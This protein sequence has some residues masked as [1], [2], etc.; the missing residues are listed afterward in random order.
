[1]AVSNIG[2]TCTGIT[3]WRA[4]SDGWFITRS[5]PSSRGSDP[6]GDFSQSSSTPCLRARMRVRH[7]SPPDSSA[8]SSS[9]AWIA[10]AVEL[11]NVC[12]LLPPMVV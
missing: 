9:P 1:M 10:R 12:G 6:S 8:T 11:T 2:Y 5:S 7:D 3:I 4:I